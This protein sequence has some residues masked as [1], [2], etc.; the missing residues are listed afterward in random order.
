MVR[1][2]SR[3]RTLDSFFSQSG[4]GG[5]GSRPSPGPSELPLSH[6]HV[7]KKPRIADVDGT[8]LGLDNSRSR[9]ELREIEDVIDIGDDG[10]D[11][12]DFVFD[13]DHESVEEFGSQQPPSLVEAGIVE[14][15]IAANA[16]LHDSV[17]DDGF[18]E[19]AE[20]EQPVDEV[21]ELMDEEV[22]IA[23]MEEEEIVKQRPFVTVELDSVVSLRQ[24][25][26]KRQC[27]TI[28]SILQNHTFV[29]CF[30]THLA[31]IQHNTSL[32]VVEVPWISRDFMYQVALY[33]FSNFGLIPV[34]P[35]VDLV[36]LILLGLEQRGE[37]WKNV[38]EQ[39]VVDKDTDCARQLLARK[40]ADAIVEMRFMLEEYFS[41]IVDE[42]GTITALPNMIPGYL[43]NLEKLAVFIL[44]LGGSV[45]YSSEKECFEGVCRVLAEF[46]AFTGISDG[47]SE[48]DY[49]HQVQHF[50]FAE[51][52]NC[53]GLRSWTATQA[54]PDGK[55][56][57]LLS[58]LPCI[59]E[60]ANLQELYK[61]FERC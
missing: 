38:I 9:Y 46:Y 2:D 11:K 49:Y 27:E 29:G 37:E 39:M 45:D 57:I 20:K 19:T 28:T 42:N 4:G 17:V 41:I 60:V 51:L 15:E 5:S 54:D 52:G 35:G 59:R 47:Q 10:D 3:T 12:L 40:V 33:G 61:I 30:D 44:D 14:N 50:L 58:R 23:E 13:S 16:I 34:D 56:S 6:T 48:E 18:I 31:L 21:D 43:P 32:L 24:E 53:I 26:S 36:E 55:D 7:E 25:L 22:S 1:T 8:G